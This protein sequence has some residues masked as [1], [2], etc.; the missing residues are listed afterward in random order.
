MLDPSV[1][2]SSLQGST[3]AGKVVGPRTQEIG[4]RVV[5][6]GTGHVGLITAASLAAIGHDVVGLD[7]DEEKIGG[8]R[9]GICPFYEPGLQAL[10]EQ[11]ANARTPAVRC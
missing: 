5:V 1:A 3:A 4:L 6:V 8:L 11:T 7:D 10:I 9:Q 2:G